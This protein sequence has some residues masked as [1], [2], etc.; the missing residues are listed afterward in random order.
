M[1]LREQVLFRRDEG[2]SWLTQDPQQMPLLLRFVTAFV[3]L[4]ALVTL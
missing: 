1:A 2:Y 3:M 4:I